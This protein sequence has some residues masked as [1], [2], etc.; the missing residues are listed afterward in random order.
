[1][2]DVRCSRVTWTNTASASTADAHPTSSSPGWPALL[3]FRLLLTKA[4]MHIVI[5]SIFY[6]SVAE[7]IRS[8][9]QLRTI[10]TTKK[11]IKKIVYLEGKKLAGIGIPLGL[12]AGNLIGYFIIP[13]GWNWLTSLIMTVVVGIFSFFI[14]MFSIRTPVKR[15]SLVSPIE[16]TRYTTYQGGATESNKLHRTIS[17]LS[18]AKVNLLRNKAIP[19][20]KVGAILPEVI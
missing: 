11:Q 14:T 20:R 13:N 15:A 6:I 8:Y 5:Y 2:V 19:H 7:N 1:M 9:G 17:P 4:D 3:P 18:L 16:A 12:I 10:G